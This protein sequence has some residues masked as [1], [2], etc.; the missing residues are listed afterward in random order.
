MRVLAVVGPSGAGKDTVINA[1]RER[2]PD[3]A[4]LRRVI[5]RPEREGDEPFEGVDDATFDRREQAGEFA[6]VWQAH[7]LRYAIPKP[8]R[9]P[10]IFNGSRKRL[11][12]AAEAFPGLEV[13]HITCAPEIR[14]QR[15][16]ARGRETAE[17]IA[18]RLT[19]D[20]PLPQGLTVHE[21]DNCGPLEDAVAAFLAVLDR[22]IG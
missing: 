16:A 13:I 18:Q 3:L 1:V 19:R 12:D 20:A 14:A 7:G 21:I 11:A 5:T 8:D 10:V 15:L 22:Q 2:R 6:L 4:I 17:D 9:S